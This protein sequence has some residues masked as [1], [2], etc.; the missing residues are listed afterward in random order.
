MEFPTQRRDQIVMGLSIFALILFM[1]NMATFL[2]QKFFD[3]NSEARHAFVV[4]GTNH[5]GTIHLHA[6]GDDG[7]H[8]WE[9]HQLGNGDVSWSVTGDEAVLHLDELKMQFGA[10]RM[11]FDEAKLR[12]E[13]GRMKLELG[14]NRDNIRNDLRNTLRG[15]LRN[16]SGRFLWRHEDGQMTVSESNS[17]WDSDDLM[18]QLREAQEAAANIERDLRLT[19]EQAMLLETIEGDGVEVFESQDES[20]RHTYKVI[21]RKKR[22]D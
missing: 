2:K 16:R 19:S 11:H 1:A 4:S 22:Q 9:M 18:Q 3:G 13:L 21:V 14:L 15:T 5:G 17:D 12:E 8:T 6:D 7:D 20:G 10:A